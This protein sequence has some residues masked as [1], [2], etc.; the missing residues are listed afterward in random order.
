VSALFALDSFGGG[1]V[2]QS[3]LAWWL[4]QKFARTK[5]C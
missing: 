4:Q 5:Q 3:F 1:F 2:L